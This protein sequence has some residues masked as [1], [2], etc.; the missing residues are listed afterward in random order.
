MSTPSADAGLPGSKAI[1]VAAGVAAR[2]GAFPLKP[3]RCI[4]PF[5]PGGGAD[6]IGRLIQPGAGSALGGVTRSTNTISTLCCAIMR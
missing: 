2:R 4:V 3:V 1:Q 6:G 5:A